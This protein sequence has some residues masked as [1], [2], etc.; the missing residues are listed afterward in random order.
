MFTRKEFSLIK[1]RVTEPRRFI[2][3]V[4]G[5]RQIGKTT[6]V[7]QELETLDARPFIFRPMPLLPRMPL[8]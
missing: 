1:Q 4:L 3:V 6:V 2:Q 8:G 5:P 7:R